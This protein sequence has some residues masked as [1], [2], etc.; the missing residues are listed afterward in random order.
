[1]GSR[2]VRPEGLR[3]GIPLQGAAV[4]AVP[5][6]EGVYQLYDGGGAV[7]KIRGVVHLRGA[8][9]DELAAGKAAY[10]CYEEHTL[11]S[12]RECHLLQQY[13]A[14]HGRMP[15]SDDLDDPF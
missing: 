5:A 3:G 11:Y 1:M 9:E 6:S 7:L 12:S 4:A 2:S 10:F 8:L 14:E 15:G 13:L